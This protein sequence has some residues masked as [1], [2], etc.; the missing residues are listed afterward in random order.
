MEERDPEHPTSQKGTPRKSTLS[1]ADGSEHDNR[2]KKTQPRVLSRNVIAD[3]SSSAPGANAHVQTLVQDH[4]FSD[5][6][7]DFL[8]W[9]QEQS[10]LSDPCVSPREEKRGP[11]PSGM[12]AVADP[13]DSEGSEDEMIR[14]AEATCKRLCARKEHLMAQGRDLSSEDETRL[15]SARE[16]PDRSRPRQIGEGGQGSGGV[17]SLSEIPSI[18]HGVPQKVHDRANPVIPPIDIAMDRGPAPAYLP[19]LVGPPVP[20]V[21]VNAV[22]QNLVDVPMGD[23][24]GTPYVPRCFRPVNRM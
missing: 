9:L 21:P 24:S 10:R 19:S 12:G 13:S 20:Y 11:I 14:A 6:G 17:L 7:A 23:V 8:A 18:S 4:K 22:T 16:I 3:S 5:L 2:A 15:H 1:T